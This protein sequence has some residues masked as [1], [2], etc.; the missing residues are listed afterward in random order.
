MVLLRSA[1]RSDDRFAVDMARTML[2]LPPVQEEE[3]EPRVEA[4]GWQVAS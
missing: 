3:P 1:V 4:P 2:N